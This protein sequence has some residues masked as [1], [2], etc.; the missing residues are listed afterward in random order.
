MTVKLLKNSD[1]EIIKQPEG[2]KRIHRE[3]EREMMANLS[4]KIMQI[5]GEVIKFF[6]GREG[7]GISVPRPGGIEPGPWQ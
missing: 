1:R 6:S 4:L 3:T 2:E 5:R 7:C